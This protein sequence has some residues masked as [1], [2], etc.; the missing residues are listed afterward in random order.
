MGASFPESAPGVEGMVE[1]P[2][3]SCHDPA[4]R[5]FPMIGFAGY[6]WQ[7]DLGSGCKE[8]LGWLYRSGERSFHG[9]IVDRLIE[10]RD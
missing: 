5:E 8:Q 2:R 9:L 1:N 3:A 6:T 7:I 4:R 10:V